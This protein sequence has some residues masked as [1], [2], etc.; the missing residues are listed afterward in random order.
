[1]ENAHAKLMYRLT[2]AVIVA[3]LLQSNRTQKK[4][5]RYN[6]PTTKTHVAGGGSTSTCNKS[7]RIDILNALQTPHASS[8]KPTL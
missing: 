1:M 5:R 2:T 8:L 3:L 6:F 4:L 7:L